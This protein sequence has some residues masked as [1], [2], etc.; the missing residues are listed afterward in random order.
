[1]KQIAFKGAN[2]NTGFSPIQAGTAQL[3]QMRSRDSQ[4]IRDLQE[5]QNQKNK[6]NSDRINDLESKYA[7]EARNRNELKTLEDKTFATREAAIAQNQQQTAQNAR[8]EQV[9][10]REDLRTWEALGNFSES[11]SEQLIQFR[12]DKNQA[13]MEEAYA[14]A[15]AEGLPANQVLAQERMEAELR[16]MGQTEEAIADEMARRGVNPSVVNQVRSGNK[17]RDYGRLKAYSEMA[18]DGY[19]SWLQ[20]QLNQLGQEAADPI[21]RAAAVQKLQQQYLKQNGLFGLSAD[22]LGPM[23]SK[24][25]TSSNGVMEAARKR[26]VVQGSTEMFEEARTTLYTQKS[27]DALNEL[28][29][30]KAVGYGSDGKTI[31]GPAAGVEAVF[32][33]LGSFNRY[34]D[35]E[36]KYLLENT[37]TNT[38]KTFA[39]RYPGRVNDLLAERSKAADTYRGQANREKDAAGK[40]KVDEV[41]DFFRSQP[42]GI[43][44]NSLEE[45]INELKQQGINTSRL[46]ALKYETKQNIDKRA[47]TAELEEKWQAGTLSLE[48]LEN[49]AIPNDVRNQWTDRVNK[50]ESARASA[51]VDQA[52]MKSTLKSTLKE[53][54]LG[55]GYQS[56]SGADGTLDLALASA[57]SEYNRNFKAY[58][59][60]MSADKAYEKA[61]NEIYEKVLNPPVGS[62]YSVAEDTS[63]STGKKNYFPF[64]RPGEVAPTMDPKQFYETV[65][66]DP[67][68]FTHKEII[69]KS[70]AYQGFETAQRNGIPQIP[71]VL[72]NAAKRSP[73]TAAELYAQQIELLTG[74]KV[75]FAPSA[76][77]TLSDQINDPRLQ[78]ILTRPTPQNVQTSILSSEA[79][80][81][82]SS[83]QPRGQSIIAMASR[84]GWDPADIAAI[85]SFETGGT[86]DPAQPGYGAASGRIGLIQAGPNEREKYGLGTGNWDQEIRG[87]E[88]YLKDRGATPGMGLEDLYATINGGN[89]NAGYT[90]DGNGTVA[91][92]PETMARLLEHKAQASERLGIIKSEYVPTRDPNNMSPTLQYFYTTG[93]ETNGGWSEHVDFK[94][95]DNPNTIED[96][97]GQYWDPDELDNYISF[98]DPEFGNITLSELRKRIP[99]PGGNFGDPRSYGPHAGWDYGTKAG[100]KLYLKNGA[101]KI[102]T[103]RVPGNGW[104]SVFKLPDGRYFAALHGKGV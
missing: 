97:W 12:D 63:A 59:E 79:A 51:G 73:Y 4:G 42:E 60:V 75:E 16:A 46:D 34:T 29:R 10:A 19:G 21:K 91:R 2:R 69:S 100:T 52:T 84:N 98:E 43:D 86:L 25:R 83:P 93:G 38:G 39:E 11:I 14:Q 3:D 104:R 89:P 22:F 103:E 82:Y 27:P 50:L 15:L 56:T 71:N 90:P 6:I 13:D 44:I 96:E 35:A 67:E 68:L 85:A 24:M 65:K 30:S 31:N 87:I 45:S 74:Q 94:Q 80:G 5:S 41:M 101:R 95:M 88:S 64:F 54:L 78:E 40:A 7:K 32:T 1:M 37:V 66:K 17:W 72:Q 102:S 48:D 61:W 20:E 70:D 62:K 47:I 81:G 92:S 23:F 77:D 58:S 57:M 33:E 28:F 36:V 49:R 8:T 53:G 18:G 99:I 55:A 9:N 26:Q 76:A